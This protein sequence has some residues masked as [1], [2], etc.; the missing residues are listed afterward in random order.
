[1]Q[2]SEL[3]IIY[4]RKKDYFP[5][6][7]D[8][9]YLTENGQEDEKSLLLDPCV[10]EDVELLTFFM[11]NI[12]C[13]SDNNCDKIRVKVTSKVYNLT[14]PDLERARIS[15]WTTTEKHIKNYLS[16]DISVNA[17]KGYLLD[18]VNRTTECSAV[19]ISCVKYYQAKIPQTV[20]WW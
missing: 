10:K 3:W 7:D 16:G 17:L 1:M 19:A 15:S 12:E 6:T 8:S 20:S 4:W 5:L 13:S 2:N 11:G 18:C 9:P 14:H